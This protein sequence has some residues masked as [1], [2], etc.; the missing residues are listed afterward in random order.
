MASLL[1]ARW[2]EW[3]SEQVTSNFLV[4]CDPQ[5]VLLP[6]RR[7]WNF[8]GSPLTPECMFVHFFG[9]HR[10]DADI[11]RCVARETAELLRESTSQSAV[12]DMVTH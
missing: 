5:A 4:A 8:N 12:L 1:H 2:A 11:Y 10:F 9:T 6:H 3:G 7:Y